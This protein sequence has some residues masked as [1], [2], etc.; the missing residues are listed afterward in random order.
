MTDTQEL[1][2]IADE[3]RAI[4]N[5]GIHFTD[6]H[7]DR[8]RY[9]QILQLSAR[10]TATIEARP[11]EEIM[12]IFTDNM[13]HIS[14]I[15]GAG[16]AVFRDGKILLIQRD[17]NQLWAIPGGLVEVGDTLS[18]AACREL[19]EEAGLRGV[20]VRLL[21]IFD[22]RIWKSGLKHQLF[23]SIFEVEVPADQQPQVCPETLANGF[24]AEDE[25]PPLSPGHDLRLPLLFKI[26]RGE[27]PA[28]YFDA[29]P[30]I[31]LTNH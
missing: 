3:L 31:D 30:Q 2:N 5:T 17:D 12:E 15:N 13:F 21:G 25:L 23:H 14:P 24:F 19:E 29:S 9:E 6:S 22:S 16:A 1:Y 27:V 8:T 4:A 7:Y 28:P 26:E 10:L 11:T 20:A 18:S